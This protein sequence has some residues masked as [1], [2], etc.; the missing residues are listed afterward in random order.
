MVIVDDHPAFTDAATLLLE[1]A[2]YVVVGVA[3][4][5][6]SVLALV[7]ET[8][9]EL[10]LLDVQLPGV[11]GFEV[12]RRLA[13]RADPPDVVLVSSR[14]AGSYGGDLRDLPVRGFVTKS[15]LSGDVLDDLVR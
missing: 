3:A 9:P 10:V 12:A 5:G 7:E 14:E 13:A 2:G 1:A 11:D 15:A 8:R 6:E 4:S